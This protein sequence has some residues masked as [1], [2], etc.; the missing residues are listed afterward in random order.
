MSSWLNVFYH[1]EL[2]RAS[3]VSSC[4]VSNNFI[5]INEAKVKTHLFLDSSLT[6]GNTVEVFRAYE[7]FGNHV[8]PVME[9]LHVYPYL[10]VHCKLHRTHIK[11][12]A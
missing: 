7:V 2:L 1:E 6:C 12:A 3:C 4:L 10:L 8:S 11:L 9:L 5:I